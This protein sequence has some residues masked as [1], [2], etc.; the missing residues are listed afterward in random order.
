MIKSLEISN[1]QSH[2]FSTLDFVPGVNVITGISDSGKSAI[3]RALLW[4]IK[5]RP[6]GGDFKNWLAK[7][8]DKVEVAIEFDNDWVVKTRINKNVYEIDGHSFEALRSDVPEPVQNIMKIDDYNIQTQFAPYFMLQ[9]SPG[10]RAK[11]LNELVGLDII[12]QVSKKLNAKI[13]NAK[14]LNG[15]RLAKIESLEQKIKE[16]PNLPVATTR[17]NKLTSTIDKYKTTLEMSK[18][19][20]I[21]IDKL[22]EIDDK[23]KNAS[24]ILKAEEA[25]LN[26]LQ[27]MN[28]YNI[29]YD[30]NEKL[31]SKI[32]TLESVEEEIKSEY[33]WLTV[34]KPAL[35]LKQKLIDIRDK[36]AQQEKLRKVY[37]NY[38]N[39]LA[40]LFVAETH[41]KYKVASFISKLEEVKVCPVC[42]QMIKRSSIAAIKDF[43]EGDYAP[44]NSD[45]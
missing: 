38:N 22:Q 2:K 20:Q 40:D 9:D 44:N 36:E 8:K 7:E 26:I 30:K 10:E 1:F 28:R 16:L 11:R 14:Q 27:K 23:T 31:K 19:L 3:F 33:D 43:I 18:S 12:D 24:I 17:Y 4:S 32:T 25:Y 29:D 39:V 35:D 5:N 34:E 15:S 45:N 6:S 37:T 13:T 42:R 41:L 21:Y